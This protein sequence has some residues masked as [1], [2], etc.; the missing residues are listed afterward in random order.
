MHLCR[1]VVCFIRKVGTNKAG[2]ATNNISINCFAYHVKKGL[3]VWRVKQLWLRIRS[4]VL[5]YRLYFY[6]QCKINGLRFQY[7]LYIFLPGFSEFKSKGTGSINFSS[8]HVW[9]VKNSSLTYTQ[10]VEILKPQ[11]YATVFSCLGV[12]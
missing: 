10:K 7:G 3:T 9:F 6:R 4:L 1:L 2:S 8:R 11:K 12:F 5:S